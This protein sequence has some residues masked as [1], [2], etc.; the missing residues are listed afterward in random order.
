MGL[1]VWFA[2]CRTTHDV[3]RVES[4]VE[5]GHFGVRPRHVLALALGAF[6]AQAVGRQALVLLCEPGGR[7]RVVWQE[8]ED[9]YCGEEGWEALEDEQPPPGAEPCCAVH[10]A[11]SVGDCALEMRESVFVL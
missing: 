2:D 8:E 4:Q 9:C 6:E 10:V 7:F 11:Y 1:V 3:V 5:Q